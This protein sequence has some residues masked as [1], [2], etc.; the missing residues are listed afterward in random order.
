MFLLVCND[1]HSCILLSYLIVL[2]YLIC[3]P[4]LLARNNNILHNLLF[5]QNS[6]LTCE[7]CYIIFLLHDIEGDIL[8]SSDSHIWSSKTDSLSEAFA[9]AIPVGNAIALSAL[10]W[11]FYTRGTTVLNRYLQWCSYVIESEHMQVMH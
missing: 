11:C 2:N 8:P 9:I 1:F 3:T 10:N 5:A 4:A 6:E 7:L